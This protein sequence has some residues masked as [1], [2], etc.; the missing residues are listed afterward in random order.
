MTPV[1]APVRPGARLADY[2]TFRLGGPCRR[3]IDCA[4]AEQVAAAVAAARAAGEPFRLIGGGSNLL[5]ADAGLPETVVRFAADIPDIRRED[6][7][8]SVSAGT[9]FDELAA[10]A[11]RA[12]LG[13]LTFATGI[14]GTVGGA[15]A[16]NAGA[17][18]EQ[19]ADRLVAVTLLEPDGV[20]RAIPRG[21]LRFAYRDS[22]LKGSDRIILCATLSLPP[23]EREG[24][25]SE[26]ARLLELRRT[27][28]PDWKKIPCAGSFFRNLEPT[29]AAGRRQSA[30]WF[31]EQAG[32]MGLRVGGARVYEKHANIP[33]KA[34]DD[35]TAA[36]VRELTRRMAEAVRTRFG[37][38]LVPEVQSWGF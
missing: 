4:T 30:G 36:D 3:L 25:L 2:T 31:L 24:L 35:C 21:A 9:A 17:F 6:N 10:F 37:L 23:A 1:G 20:V 29:S 7:R 28:H 8:V 19:I 32:V 22:E 16:G 18:G 15:I 13:G 5:I 11:A 33:I 26:R 27:M 38:T 12:G 34:S 14:P